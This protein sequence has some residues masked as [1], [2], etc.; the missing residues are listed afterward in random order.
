MVVI[1]IPL[2]FFLDIRT[3]DLLHQDIL[4]AC[5][6]LILILSTRFSPPAERRQVWIMVGVAT[7]VEV[8][9]SIVWGIY[10]Y[11][12][13]NVPLWVPPG[14]GLIYLFA[15]RSIRTPFGRSHGVLLTR[16]AIVC[17]TAWAVFGLTLEPLLL[18][19]LDLLGALWWPAFI[20]FMRKPS[21]PM[22]AAAFFITSYLELW[23]TSMGNWAWQVYAP[24]SHIPDGNPPS[25]ISAG[26][27]LMDFMSLSIA[28]ALPA[29]GFLARWFFRARP[30]VA[31]PAG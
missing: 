5:A 15:L 11:R 28:A 27:C 6:W 9:S 24:V 3:T 7:S 12:F 10:R 14:H 21:A 18:H 26:Y 4:G 1:L 19:R 30:R 17:A 16:A 22:F 29:T 23:G 25:V 13:G 2:A 8:W 20:W 31:E